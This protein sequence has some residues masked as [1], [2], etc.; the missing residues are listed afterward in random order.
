MH[1]ELNKAYGKGNFS[2]R[3]F[4]M[5]KMLTSMELVWNDETCIS[6]PFNMKWYHTRFG[7]GVGELL[8]WDS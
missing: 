6:F 7:P 2:Q 5:P 4:P 1:S 3:N 8:G